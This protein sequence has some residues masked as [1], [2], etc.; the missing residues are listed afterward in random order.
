MGGSFGPGASSHGF[1]SKLNTVCC[2]S[3]LGSFSVLSCFN[4]VFPVLGVRFGNSEFCVTLRLASP[5]SP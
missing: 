5:G 1:N 2:S 3:S 4:D